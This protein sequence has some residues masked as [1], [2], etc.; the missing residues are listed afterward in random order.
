MFNSV[1]GR[2]VLAEQKANYLEAALS[3]MLDA[4][5]GEEFHCLAEMV[6]VL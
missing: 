6:F 5:L 4:P 3:R 1:M 2:I